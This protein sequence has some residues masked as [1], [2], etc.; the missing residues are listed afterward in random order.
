M[1]GGIIAMG[2]IGASEEFRVIEMQPRRPEEREEL[3]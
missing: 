3:D 1:V 2:A